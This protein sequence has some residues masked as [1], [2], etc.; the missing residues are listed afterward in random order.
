MLAAKGTNDSSHKNAR[1]Q[2]SKHA[3]MEECCAAGWLR[4][5]QVAQQP[6]SQGAL[7]GL[8]SGLW[9]EKVG[10]CQKAGA[11]CG[12]YVCHCGNEAGSDRGC[13]RSVGFSK[14]DLGGGFPCL[15]IR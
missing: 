6:P 8:E 4:S 13:G 3:L 15:L 12:S 1:I 14:L 9:Q 2:P 11:C 10:L 5:C 7:P